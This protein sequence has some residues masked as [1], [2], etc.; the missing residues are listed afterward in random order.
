MH[1]TRSFRPWVPVLAALLLAAAPPARA[2]LSTL[3]PD[4]AGG[5]DSV[6]VSRFAGSQLVGFQDLGFGQAKFFLPATEAGRDPKKDINLDK[7]VTAEGQVTRRLY[8]APVGKTPLEVHRNFEQA[9]HTAGVKLLTAVDGSGAYWD[10]DSHWRAGFGQL[11][12]R[13]PFATDIS[14]FDRSAYY[15]YGTLKRNGADIHISVLTGNTSVFTH[16]TY[17]AKSQDALTA[18]AI[19]IVE[20]KAMQAG[21]VTVSADTIRKGLDAEGRIALYGIY[22]ETGKAELQPESKPQLEQMAAMLK[23]QPALRVFIV[24]HT[25]N[26]GSLDGN[27]QLSQQRAQAV[28]AALARNHGI[29]A[30]RLAA[31]GVANLAPVASNAAEAGRA[32]NRR[33]EMVAQ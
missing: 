20:P 1:S 12:F 30:G 8:I 16:D 27:L 25:D 17:K 18:V 23:Q 2:Q 5:K 3:G 7:P 28:A 15:L 14:P 13:K 31:R 21:Q 4:V 24:G 26:Q 19:Q 6:L 9:L 33:V 22:F 29:D 10:A 32:K 11:S